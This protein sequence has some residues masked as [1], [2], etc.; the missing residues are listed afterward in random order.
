MPETGENVAEEFQVSRADQDAFAL[1]SQQRTATAVAA[2]RFD[3]AMIPVAVPAR[4]GAPTTVDT[5]RASA[6]RHDA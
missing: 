4:K 3:D 5:R 6:P 1:R 2:G